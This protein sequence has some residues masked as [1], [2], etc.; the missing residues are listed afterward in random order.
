M[1][2]LDFDRSSR[3][4]LMSR[5]I[6]VMAEPPGPILDVGGS[7]GLLQQLLPKYSVIQVDVA[8]SDCDVLGSGTALPFRDD[9][10][11]MATTLDVLEHIPASWRPLLLAEM[12]R[13]SSTGLTVAGPFDD[14]AVRRAEEEVDRLYLEMTGRPNRWLAEHRDYGL[15]A[16]D[17]VIT[18]L[19]DLGFATAV[20]TSNPLELWT[21]LQMTDFV[22][23]ETH[24]HAAMS[25]VHERLVDHYLDA[26]DAEI[27]TYRHLIIATHAPDL[28]ERAAEAMRSPTRGTGWDTR[29]ALLALDRAIAGGVR[30]AVL[31][32]QRV[33]REKNQKSDRVDTLNTEIR[34]MALERDKNAALASQEHRLRMDLERSVQ[35]QATE[36][37]ELRHKYSS[38]VETA[39]DVRSQ[40]E[41]KWKEKVQLEESL[42]AT[43]SAMA[44]ES[45]E[46]DRATQMIANAHRDARLIARSRRWRIGG[47]VLRPLR[48]FSRRRSSEDAVTR[49][50]RGLAPE[51]R[52]NMPPAAQSQVAATPAGR[53]SDVAAV[54]ALAKALEGIAQDTQAITESRRWRLGRTI[55]GP[56]AFFRKGREPADRR[57]VHRNHQLGNLLGTAGGT[58]PESI[59]R[60]KDWAAAQASDAE[61]LIASRAWKTGSAIAAVKIKSGEPAIDRV[62]RNAAIVRDWEAP[63]APAETPLQP[64]G[65]SERLDDSGP[66]PYAVYIDAVEPDV[67]AAY[68]AD[69]SASACVVVRAPDHRVRSRLRADETASRHR[70]AGFL[71]V[72]A[73]GPTVADVTS[74][75]AS[76]S[77]DYVVIIEPGDQVDPVLPHVLA[78]HGSADAVVTDHDVLTSGSRTSPAF[79][80][81]ISV[82]LLVECDVIRRAIAIRTPALLGLQELSSLD[83]HRGRSGAAV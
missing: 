42:R 43:R 49:L 47:V 9:S 17:E 11:A 25:H 33:E 83:L 74:A 52:S 56:V 30:A 53:G 81:G 3:Y 71:D 65:P 7:G 70:A 39:D 51:S 31:D 67:K 38:A 28:A 24:Q 78:A 55:T 80:G 14:E 16:L 40:L 10:F 20:R 46:L 35:D 79:L 73:T 18:H 13:V 63:A 82:D 27:P 68:P 75:A 44:R 61:R 58:E 6:R 62:R 50:T 66:D 77:S 37:A 15:P 23:A 60:L 69:S 41:A 32:R 64:P 59:R 48:V 57:L 34:S 21:R 54:N 29:D 26:G 76:T 12:A 72:V 36:M 4:V 19:S 8:G 2:T 22:A 45:E 1:K 5:A